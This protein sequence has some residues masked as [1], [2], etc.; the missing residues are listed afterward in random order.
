MDFRNKLHVYREKKYLFTIHFNGWFWKL[1]N[2][3]NSQQGVVNNFSYQFEWKNEFF[4][5]DDV[6]EGLVDLPP[7]YNVHVEY[8]NLELTNTSAFFVVEVK[9]LCK[10]SLGCVVRSTNTVGDLKKMCDA[11]PDQI[12]LTYNGI[13]MDNDDVK[14]GLYGINQPCKLNMIHR[15]GHADYHITRQKEFQMNGK[16]ICCV[17][18]DKPSRYMCSPCNHLCLCDS[19]KNGIGDTCP[20]CRT[21][22]QKLIKVFY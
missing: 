5:N 12:I 15:L 1:K 13:R 10:P 17:C 22:Y 18:L 2:I 6:K 3:L 14:I 9:R 19:C 20:I 8:E 7:E 16:L 4:S 11:H 21:T